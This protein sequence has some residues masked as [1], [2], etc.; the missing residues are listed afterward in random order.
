MQRWLSLKTSL[1]LIAFLG[2]SA[3]TAAVWPGPARS[4]QNDDPAGPQGI[5]FT[6]G[7]QNHFIRDNNNGG[8]ILI[9]TGMVRNSYDEPR[10]FIQLNGNLLSS[11]GAFLTGQMVFAGNVLTEEELVTLPVQELFGRL[12]VREGREGQNKNVQPGVEIP[13][14]I[15]FN[16]L[17][18]NMAE[19][20]IDVVASSPVE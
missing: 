18:D 13:F 8:K 19:Y 9:V 6:R 1:V 2:M 20:R 14:M 17:P 5:T 7:M 4:Q 15:V 11:D 12:Q 3:I 10:A 16:D